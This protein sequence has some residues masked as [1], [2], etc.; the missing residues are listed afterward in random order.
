MVVEVRTEKRRYF[1]I[2]FKAAR[3]KTVDKRTENKRHN[4]PREGIN[5]RKPIRI[6]VFKMEKHQ[7]RALDKKRVDFFLHRRK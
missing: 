6:R 7:E 2:R 4:P 5:E 3:R 1:F